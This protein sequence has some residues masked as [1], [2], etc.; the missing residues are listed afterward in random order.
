MQM[1]IS[2][3]NVFYGGLNPEIDNVFLTHGEM[4]P[5]RSLGPSQDITPNSPVIVMSRKFCTV[6]M[7]FKGLIKYHLFLVQ[8]FGR[9][10]GSPAETDYA[11]LQQ[12]KARA[13]E[14]MEQWVST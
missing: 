6:R 11:V 4:D 5:R 9:D 2:R 1:T 10:F 3:T 7:I 12:T 13:R 14:L 8:S